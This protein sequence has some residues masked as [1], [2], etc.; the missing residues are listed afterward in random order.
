MRPAMGCCIARHGVLLRAQCLRQ[1]RV[2]V[3]SSHDVQWARARLVLLGCRP[4]A[5]NQ[6]GRLADSTLEQER[7]VAQGRAG[8]R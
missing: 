1:P 5:H 6:A 4:W 3:G 2:V 8:C 7:W